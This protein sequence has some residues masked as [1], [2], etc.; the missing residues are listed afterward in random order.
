M[1]R[2]AMP[3]MIQVNSV[4]RHSIPLLF[5]FSFSARLS[6]DPIHPGGPM[7]GLKKK[8]FENHSRN[9]QSECSSARLLRHLRW[10]TRGRSTLLHPC[11][12]HS[13]AHSF[14]S[15]AFKAEN[16]ACNPALGRS[17]RG[18]VKGNRCVSF[19]LES[20]VREWQRLLCH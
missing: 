6:P 20:L 8:R 11:F 1:W 18:R 12:T 16:T 4:V 14:E 5:L 13:Q 3:M 9:L 15:K 17:L 7:P 2:R 10:H 19:C